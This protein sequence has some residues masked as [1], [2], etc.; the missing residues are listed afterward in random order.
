MQLRMKVQAS[1]W[2]GRTVYRAYYQKANGR[3]ARFGKYEAASAG[4]LVAIC[5]RLRGAATLSWT[6]F[7]P[8]PP[9]TV[10]IVISP[11]LEYAMLSAYHEYRSLPVGTVE[12]EEARRRFDAA[13]TEFYGIEGK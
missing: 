1:E 10:T 2:Q 5:E 4:Q 3:W 13:R 11:E 8:E 7:V 12:R 9:A 6:N